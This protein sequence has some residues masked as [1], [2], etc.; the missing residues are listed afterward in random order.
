[1]V[2]KYEF[3][4]IYISTSFPKPRSSMYKVGPLTIFPSVNTHCPKLCDDTLQYGN[5]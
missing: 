5:C 3:R 1:M 2:I 4:S